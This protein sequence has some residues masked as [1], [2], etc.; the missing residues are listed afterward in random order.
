MVAEI[1]E[2][3][4]FRPGNS[5]RECS[6][7]AV[8][9]TS[10][11]GHMNAPRAL[12]YVD[13]LDARARHVHDVPPP[14]AG[15]DLDAFRADGV[16]GVP[17]LHGWPG[18]QQPGDGNGHKEPRG[19]SPTLSHCGRCVA[20][21]PTPAAASSETDR[22]AVAIQPTVRW[23][24]NI[25]GIDLPRYPRPSLKRG[26][27]SL[28]YRLRNRLRRRLILSSFT[29]N[30]VHQRSS[31]AS[32]MLKSQ[33]G[34]TVTFDSG[35]MGTDG[36]RRTTQNST[37]GQGSRSEQCRSALQRRRDW[38]AIERN[39][40]T[41]LPPPAFSR[42]FVRNYAEEVDSIQNRSSA[43]TLRNLPHDCPANDQRPKTP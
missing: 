43:T 6:V 41:A 5:T 8:K 31:L 23:S 22:M 11:P 13:V 26:G 25:S 9:M 36:H 15:L 20:S 27:P 16:A 3:L 28:D 34:A 21:Q 4:Y 14:D 29:N 32:A 30:F 10:R 1:E 17:G 18:L 38:S 42:G 2:T 39:D 24:C 40:R 12:R 33:S 19:K 7:P 35:V 37:R